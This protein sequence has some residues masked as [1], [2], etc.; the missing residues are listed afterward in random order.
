MPRVLSQSR[1]LS[2][3]LFIGPA[4]SWTAVSPTGG[5]FR[6]ADT[7]AGRA[8]QDQTPGEGADYFLWT[9]SAPWWIRTVLDQRKNDDDNTD[10]IIKPR[11]GRRFALVPPPVWS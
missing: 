1:E 4:G 5:L 3:R 9:E 10:D 8:G 11:R 7:Q 6:L 2:K